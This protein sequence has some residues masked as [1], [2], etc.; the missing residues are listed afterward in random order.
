MTHHSLSWLL[1]PGLSCKS[2]AL[3]DKSSLLAGS[4]SSF[5][6]SMRLL[7]EF[8]CLGVHCLQSLIAKGQGGLTLECLHSSQRSYTTPTLPVIFKELSISKWEKLAFQQS[9]G[10]VSSIFPA[11][12]PV[13]SG[14]DTPWLC[15]SLITLLSSEAWGQEQSLP[16]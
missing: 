15:H 11:S 5:L 7:G 9:H 4:I 6:L 14:C 2:S 8:Q 12:L 10:L 13:I 3:C 16:P 1:P